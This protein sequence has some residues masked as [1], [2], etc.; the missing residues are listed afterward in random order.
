MAL[1]FRLHRFRFTLLAILTF[2]S[3]MAASAQT[4]L[5]VG[6]YE[7]APK[8]GFDAAGQASGIEVDILREIAAAENWTLAFVPCEW[9]TCLDQLKAGK[10]DLLPDVA[11][12][13][14]RDAAF[15]LHR[16]P[17]LHSWSQ[18]YRHPRVAIT[19]ILDLKGKR[20]ALLG[21]SIQQPFFAT[22]SRNFGLNAVEVPAASM[23][24]AFRLVEQGEADAVVANKFFGDLYAPRYRLADTPIVFQPASLFFAARKGSLAGELAA[25][26][27]HLASWQAD[28][29]S[30]Y[31][32]I[33]RRWQGPAAQARIPPWLWWGLGVV[34]L[35][36][37][38]ALL[39]AGWLRREVA[40]RTR[41]WR[42]SERKLSTILD[43]VDSLIYIKDASYRYDYVNQAVCKMMGKSRAEIIGKDDE[44]LFDADTAALIRQQDREVIERGRRVVAELVPARPNP[45]AATFQSRKLPLCRDDGS[46]YALCG[47]S[48]DISERK[49]IEDS[50]RV[51]ATV[52]QS[53]E[54]MFVMGPDRRMLDA[55]HAFSAMS[56]LADGAAIGMQLPPFSFEPDGPD[57][58]D[59][60]WEVVAREGQWRQQV[61]TRRQDGAQYPAWLS[62]TAV[63]DAHGA[64]TNYVGTQIDIT[65]QKLAQDEIVKLAFYDPLTGLPNRRLLLERLEHSLTV[66]HRSKLGGAVLFLDLDNFKDLNDTRGHE[67]GDQLLLQVA[68]RL[69]A[70]SR[71]GD[72]VARLGGDEFVILLEGVEGSESEVA[73]SAAAAAWKILDVIGRPFVIDGSA[74][75]ATCS[76]GAALYLDEDLQVNDLMKRADLAMYE[77]KKNGRNT[78]RFFHGDMASAVSNRTELESEL[79][80]AIAASQ[81]TLHY[82]SQVDGAGRI[83]GAEALLRWPHPQRGMVAPIVFIGV[84]EESGLIVPL[85]QWVLRTACLQLAAWA[86]MPHLRHLTLAV[87]VSAHQFREADFVE[88]VLALLE[89][90]GADPT[91][92]K[93]ELTESLLIDNV[94]G[95]VA[96]MNRLKARGIGFALDD[97]G[98]GFSSLAYL[99]RLPL[100]QLKI[101]H[102]FVRD[103]L[104]DPNDAAIARSIV[105]LAAA[106]G[107]GIIAEGVETEAQRSFLA[108]IGCEACQGYLFSHPVAVDQFERLLAPPAGVRA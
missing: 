38:S 98:T 62:V 53:Q 97:F 37:V 39:A 24:Q 22:M 1:R 19:S 10:I 90:S 30:V 60:M 70:C 32:H 91:R 23:E 99:K 66:H 94:E 46:V 43:S 58:R 31:F 102:S 8:L 64:T 107:L 92:L 17:A 26:D 81:L 55:N 80:A 18:V 54:A 34:L 57:M 108:E 47:I 12:S 79:R 83:T 27:R 85:G 48:T 100:D 76:I 4:R 20:V 2:V 41:D 82:Q 6:I 68:Q 15:A 73:D 28:P 5:T 35:L 101:D 52:F 42:D 3:C 95:T 75:H 106:L 59:F 16:V 44:Q 87:N 93:L 78:L 65:A 96:K 51:A 29:D 74:H 50:L 67:I 84:A 69:A 25:I 72:T 71:D 13:E 77:A 89:E 9:Q 86:R 63:R 105:A 7:N 21:G 61:W 33:L 104:V 11:Y 45:S 88:R 49:H 56:G 40:A 103:L 36:L 14:E